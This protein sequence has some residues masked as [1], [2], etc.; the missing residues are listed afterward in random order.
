MTTTNNSTYLL[1]YYNP[2][3]A[4]A[5]SPVPDAAALSSTLTMELSIDS[6]V[7]CVDRWMVPYSDWLRLLHV[8]YHL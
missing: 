1:N 8:T 4:R 7:V 2:Q 5:V 6:F 3:T